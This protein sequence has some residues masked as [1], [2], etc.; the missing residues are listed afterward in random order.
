MTPYR[1]P[2]VEDS[3]TPDPKPPGW[4]SCHTCRHYDRRCQV[5]EIPP[6]FI[7]VN[8]CTTWQ[9]KTRLQRFEGNLLKVF[10][11]IDELLS[12]RRRKKFPHRSV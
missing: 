6:V 4:G 11:K 1:L 9:P 5:K 12:P 3:L 2:V 10:N 8:Q 7:Q